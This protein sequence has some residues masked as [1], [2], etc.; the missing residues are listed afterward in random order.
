M[1]DAEF[2][3][4]WMRNIGENRRRLPLKEVARMAWRESARRI[5]A[6]M[7]RLPNDDAVYVSPLNEEDYRA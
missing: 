5:E 7:Y 2:Q 6:R 4:W 1:N 3:D